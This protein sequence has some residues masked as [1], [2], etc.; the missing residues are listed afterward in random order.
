[1]ALTTSKNGQIIT[2]PDA[3]EN[4]FQFSDDVKKPTAITT[5]W[6]EVVAGDIQ[7][8]ADESITADHH[9]WPVGSK[10]PMTVH[11]TLHY[12]GSS[13]SDKFVVTV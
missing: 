12:K 3:N 11:K 4:T 5:W 8:A 6:I 1:M 13:A 2:C 10:I 9:T 7:F